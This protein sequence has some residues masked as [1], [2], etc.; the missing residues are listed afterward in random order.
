MNYDLWLEELVK[1][2]TPRPKAATN[3]KKEDEARDTDKCSTLQDT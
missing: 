1:D 3:G 2:P